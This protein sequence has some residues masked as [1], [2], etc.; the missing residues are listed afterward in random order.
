MEQLKSDF[1]QVIKDDRSNREMTNWK[2]TFLEYLDIVRA[3]PSITKLAHARL[4][5]VIMKAGFQNIQDLASPLIKRVF[6]D[7]SLKNYDF[8]F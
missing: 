1:E 7:E 6:K 4:N 8:F 2:G 5:D 3:D